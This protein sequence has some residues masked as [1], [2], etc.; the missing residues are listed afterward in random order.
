MPR[1][2]PIRF[3]FD[4]I[5]PYAYVAWKRV[6]A[7]AAEHDR[8]VVCVPILFAALLDAHGTRGPAEVPATRVYVFKDALRRAAM[9]GLP[10]VPPP[11]HPFNPRLALRVASLD[12]DASTRRA[13]IDV[14][15]D[16]TWG[17]G[18]GVTDP[19]TV[20]SHLARVGVDGEAA[21]RAAAS[22]AVKA[23][24]RAQTDEAIARGVFGVPTLL[25]DGELFW[26]YDAFPCAALRL[27]GEDPVDETLLARWRDL[28]AA[29]RRP[30]AG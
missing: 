12:L 1:G 3:Y 27:R 29:A 17:G 14:L 19:A 26:G 13:V 7:L 24:V 11:A 21:V 22:E 15:F 9:A 30:G 18:P 28:P 23:R 20:A 2:E 25:V 5:S 6:H 10:L 16:A 4:F 8:E